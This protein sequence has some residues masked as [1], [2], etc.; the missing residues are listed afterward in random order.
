[1]DIARMTPAQIQ[2]MLTDDEE[3]AKSTLTFNTMREY[4]DWKAAQNV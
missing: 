1:M 3:D 2:M 4:M